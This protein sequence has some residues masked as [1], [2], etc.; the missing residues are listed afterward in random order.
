MLNFS[1][2][3]FWSNLHITYA[4]PCLCDNKPLKQSLSGQT[5]QFV[6]YKY[7]GVEPGDVVDDDDSLI[8]MLNSVY[9][10]EYTFDHIIDKYFKSILAIFSSR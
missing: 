6:I 1:I 10:I 7:H 3:L 4:G 5:T 2:C 9:V 8:W